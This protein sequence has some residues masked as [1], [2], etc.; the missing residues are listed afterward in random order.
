[1]I[2]RCICG[3]AVVFNL[4]KERHAQLE[5]IA[6]DRSL[7]SDGADER[8][9]QALDEEKNHRFDVAEYFRLVGW[10]QMCNDVRSIRKQ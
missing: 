1:M 3:L 9:T 6:L 5:K 2:Q 8:L 7:S 4:L 10:S